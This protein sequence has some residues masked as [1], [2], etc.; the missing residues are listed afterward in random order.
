MNRAHFIALALAAGL[1]AA[2]VATSTAHAQEALTSPAGALALSDTGGEAI[3]LRGPR[4]MIG[5]GFGLFPGL[6]FA[7]MYAGAFAAWIPPAWAL[8]IPVMGSALAAL[9]IGILGVVRLVRQK[10]LRR[11]ADRP[12]VALLS[13]VG[14]PSLATVWSF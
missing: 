4:L 5:L 3:D 12:A 2:T 1:S 14:D 9:V 11:A 7:S 8:A 10:R 13:P 6:T